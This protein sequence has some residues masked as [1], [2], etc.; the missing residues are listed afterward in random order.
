M[1]YAFNQLGRNGGGS[2]RQSSEAGDSDKVSSSVEIH[3]GY[4][5]TPVTVGGRPNHALIIA[6]DPVTGEQYATRAGPGRSGFRAVIRAE[7][8]V[9]DHHFRD[10]PAAVHTLQKLGTVNMSMEVFVTRANEF[11]TFINSQ[12]IAY[13]GAT[14]NSNSY[15]FSFA[16]SLGLEQRPG[17]T[18]FQTPRRLHGPIH[19]LLRD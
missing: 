3:L 8:D 11:S 2:S 10:A 7:S 6:T 19:C 12:D 15:A 5:D 18:L 9:F 1:A 4:T 14:Q 16:E 17:H 13:L